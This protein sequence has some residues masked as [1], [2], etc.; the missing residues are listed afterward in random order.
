MSGGK[1]AQSLILQNQVSSPANVSWKL[2]KQDYERVRNLEAVS[3]ATMLRNLIKKRKQEAC[4]RLD[5]QELQIV[6]DASAMYASNPINS[7]LDDQI[8]FGRA[9]SRG[10]YDYS[11]FL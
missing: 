11:N 7:M 4:N 8:E 10:I 3:R 1:N 2:D 6:S 9:Q 5:R